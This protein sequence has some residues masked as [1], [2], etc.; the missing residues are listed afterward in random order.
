MAHQFPSSPGSG[1]GTGAGETRCSAW[2]RCT[3]S[4]MTSSPSIKPEVTTARVGV[5]AL[6]SLTPRC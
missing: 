1:G 6:S 2:T 5:A 4:A 3:P